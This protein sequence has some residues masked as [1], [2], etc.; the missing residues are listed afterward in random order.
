MA[1][2][3]CT[4]CGL[5]RIGTGPT[6]NAE[7]PSYSA[8]NGFCLPCGDEG[9]MDIAHNNGHESI[10]EEDC[11]YCHPEKDLTKVPVKKGYTGPKKQGVRRPQLNHKG[12]A[13][14]QTPKGRRECKAAFWAQATVYS[15]ATD[16][17][18]LEKM[19]AEMAAWDAKQAPRPVKKVTPLTMVPVG[20][21]NGVV[22][23]LKATKPRSRKA[24]PLAADF[25]EDQMLNA[26]K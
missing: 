7:D 1:K 26:N 24:K 23:Q 16:P 2:G 19:A 11:W 22:K 18:L 12:H 4:I 17:E 20:P 21:K 9:Q 5:R 15:Q 13:H 10:S 8:Q 6:V 25:S 14:E 3:M